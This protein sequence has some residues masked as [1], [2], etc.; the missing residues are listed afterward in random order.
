MSLYLQILAALAE[1]PTQQQRLLVLHTPLGAEV[2]LAERARIDEAIAPNAADDAPCACR[3]VVHAL[4]AD[5]HIELKHL[6][7]QPALLELLTAASRTSLRPFHGH[8]TEAALVGSDGGLARY[9]LVIEPWLAFLA[10]R[11]DAYVFQR[12]SVIQIVEQ[13]FADYQAQGKLAPAWRWDLADPAVYAERSLSIQYLESDLDF[14]TRL[15]REEGLFSWFEHES[16]IREGDVASPSL[17]RHTLVIADHNG[18]F[19]PNAQAQVLA[20]V[21]Q[22]TNLA[23]RPRFDGWLS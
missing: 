12:A 21:S 6:I 5:T 18:A 22:R 15:L 17:G 14:I 3:V 2:L 13:V 19:K 11:T 8:I 4:A 7:G 9:R 1:A 10:H 16:N 20:V 23:V